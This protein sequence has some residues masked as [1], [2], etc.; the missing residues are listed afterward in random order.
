MKKK[1]PFA[2]AGAMV[3]ACVSAATAG[4]MQSELARDTLSLSSTQQKKAW[5]DLYMGPWSQSGPSG[6]NPVVGAVL[7]KGV[8]TAP[9]TKK[10]ARDVP[11]LKPYDFS[12]AQHKVL[13][14]NPTDKKIAEVI[15]R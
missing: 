6:F 11:A 13:I 12:L 15:A 5:H 4:S 14:V 2:L 1:M 7:P 8:V 9:I 10:A 3:L